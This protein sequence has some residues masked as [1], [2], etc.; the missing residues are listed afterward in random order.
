ME[1]LKQLNGLLAITVAV[2]AVFWMIARR[3]LARARKDRAD[4][5]RTSLVLAEER[6]VLEHVAH[7]ASLHEILTILTQAVERLA[8]GCMC[9]ILLVDSDGAHLVQGA[10]PNLPAGFWA[11]CQNIPIAPDLG[12]CASAAFRVEVTIAEDIATDHRWASIRSLAL[13]HGLRACWS[14]PI[15]DSTKGSALGTFAMYYSHPAKPAE[16]EL[17]MVEAGAQLAGRAIER[18]REHEHL[19]EQVNAKERAL[20]DLAAAQ[21]RLMD[22]SRQSG[23]AEIAIGV[24][25]NVGNVLNSV[26]VSTDLVAG[27]IRESKVDNL[28]LV[29][30][31]LHE[32]QGHLDEYLAND[33]KGP[34][35]LPYLSKLSGHFSRE[36]Q[37]LLTEME[38]LRGNLGHIKEI[39]SAQQSHAHVSG[40]SQEV[41]LEN[42]IE[43]AFHMIHPSFERHEIDVQRDFAGLP[44]LMSDKHLLLQILLNLV[45]NAKQA[46]K[47][48]NGS[49]RV[50]RVRTRRIGENFASVEI[51]DT[52]VGIEPGNLTKIFAQGFTTRRDGHGF[53]LHSSAL[54]ARQ[55]GGSLRA[56][57]QGPGCGATF[58]LE[59]PFTQFVA[60]EPLEERAA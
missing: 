36:R 5:E 6:R 25:H 52:G 33:P 23:M 54:A 17:R 12:C 2:C 29:V 35:M 28:A 51:E 50:V 1:I 19:I 22:L 38:L 15:R 7:G 20:S 47:D 59:I 11:A 44:P 53:G 24:L 8:P 40:L 55:M 10:A 14:A 39:V 13:D 3:Q 27:K 31:R 42:L 45:R 37:S 57:S 30:N 60:N 48:S 58:I 43:D 32:H 56:E 46:V 26:N 49:E 34:H 9:S 21:E 16:L 41:S 4:L 18:L